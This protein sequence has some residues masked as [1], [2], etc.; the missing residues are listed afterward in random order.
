MD[1]HGGRGRPAGRGGRQLVCGQG[2]AHRQAA[3]TAVG[4]EDRLA[5][6]A[7]FKAGVERVDTENDRLRRRLLGLETL[8]RAFARHVAQLTAQVREA[9]VEPCPPPTGSRS[10]TAPAP[11]PPRRSVPPVRGV[12]SAPE[13]PGDEPERQ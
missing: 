12:G 10:T 13:K 9:G 1:G 11:D 3:G 7:V 8:V 5:D 6:L 2:D 4:P